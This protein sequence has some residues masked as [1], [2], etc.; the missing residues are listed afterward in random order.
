MR[1]VTVW[2]SWRLVWWGGGLLVAIGLLAS[3]LALVP[4]VAH[5][6][7]NRGP[8]ELTMDWAALSSAARTTWDQDPAV[9]LGA[10]ATS[11]LNSVAVAEQSVGQLVDAGQALVLSDEQLRLW[12]AYVGAAGAA[13]GA[14]G[15]G[16]PPARPSPGPGTWLLR[17]GAEPLRL[18]APL[19]EALALGVGLPEEALAAARGAGLPVLLRYPDRRRAI[20]WLLD[21]T[22]GAGGL[23]TSRVIIFEGSSVPD[24]ATTAEPMQRG[25]Y[26]VGLIEFASQRGAGQLAR[27]LGLAAVG[28]HSMKAEEMAA[29]TV[30]AAVARYMRAVRE[31]GVRVLYLRPAPTPDQTVALVHS[32]STALEQEGF[33]TGLARPAGVLPAPTPG[34]LLLM[35]LGAGGLAAWGW[36]AWVGRRGR[37]QPVPVLALAGL[38]GL[39]GGAAVAW[40]RTQGWDAPASVLLR[41]LGALAVALVAPV[42]ATGAAMAAAGGSGASRRPLRGAASGLATFVGV[43]AA[44][45]LLVAGLLSD[46]L[47]MLRLEQFRGVK[48]AHALPPALVAVAV[49]RATGVGLAH[50][51]EWARRPVRWIDAVAAVLLLAAGVYYVVRTGNEAGTVSE[52]ERLARGWLERA[53]AVR[54][55]TKEFLIAFPALAA[56]LYVRIHGLE[57]RWPLLFAGLMAVAAIGSVSVV[58]SFAHIHTPLLITARREINGL[59]LGLV[60]GAAAWAV[61]LGL[62][63]RAGMPH[64]EIGSEGRS[65]GVLRV[66]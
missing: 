25:G 16:E 61:A 28:V 29:T 15:A 62:L 23:A 59:A 49:L 18:P 20:P 48:L 41:Q 32:L 50:A 57:R 2:N 5:E 4:R 31:R 51:Y 33:T 21:A 7:A 27:R 8:V 35:G 24:P 46:S 11:G 26:A 52:L 43:S 66:R 60:T 10:L 44:G 36:A 9:V 39:S 55:R 3:A 1:P 65:V 14:G 42:A 53:M 45:G 13:E 38:L 30:D 6:S 47:F 12:K 63:R 54:P 58:N 40:G 17:P 56:G 64:E 22:A 34:L 37:L 19:P